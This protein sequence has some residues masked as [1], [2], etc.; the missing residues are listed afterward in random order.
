MDFENL[1]KTAAKIRKQYE[2]DLQH[3]L[4]NPENNLTSKENRKLYHHYKNEIES[5]YDYIADGIKMKSKCEW[6]EHGEK[7]T[8][9]FLNLEKSEVFKT[10]SGNLLK[11]KKSQRNH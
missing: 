3:K 9:L 1:Q 8:K 6:Y 4:K 10:E 5:I 2:I 11:K 7:S